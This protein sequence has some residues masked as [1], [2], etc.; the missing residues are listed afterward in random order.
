MTPCAHWCPLLN[1]MAMLAFLLQY[2]TT[3]G[4]LILRLFQMIARI[5]EVP[6]AVPLR[7][8]TCRPV[9][10]NIL[11]NAPAIRSGATVALLVAMRIQ[12][13]AATV[14]TPSLML[15]IKSLVI[16]IGLWFLFGAAGPVAS[17]ALLLMKL[18]MRIWTIWLTVSLLQI[19][20]DKLAHQTLC[21]LM[22]T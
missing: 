11:I 19:T 9:P 15:L 8:G 18:F 20:W 14:R 13:T 3:R 16:L 4:T 2:M 6:A 21:T 7:T 5:R 1:V 17:A 22:K 10:I 12:T